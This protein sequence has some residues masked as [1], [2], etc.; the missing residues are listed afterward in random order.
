MR[1]VHCSSRLLGERVSASGPGGE[2]Y[3]SRGVSASFLGGVCF[4]SGGRLPLVRGVSPP[5][6][7]EFLIHACENITFPLVDGNNMSMLNEMTWQ[8]I[9]KDRI[10]GECW[11]RA[12]DSC[13]RLRVVAAIEIWGDYYICLDKE[14]SL[15]LWPEGSC[16]LLERKKKPLLQM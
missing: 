2:G 12:S 13:L 7:T 8:D 10:L 6:W 11:D 3:L 14:T 1:T 15:V 9:A 16:F 4:W 5:P